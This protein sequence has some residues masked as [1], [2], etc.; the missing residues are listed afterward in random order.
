M[1]PYPTP[2]WLS[3]RWE[4][5]SELVNLAADQPGQLRRLQQ[6]LRETLGAVGAPAEQIERL[7]LAGI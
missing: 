7:G 2:T 1:T 4:D 3:D 5:P 6:V